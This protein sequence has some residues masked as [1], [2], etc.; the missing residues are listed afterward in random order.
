MSRLRVLI[1]ASLLSALAATVPVAVMVYATWDRAVSLEQDR[2]REIAE[3]ALRRA[4]QSYDES[5][6]ALKSAEA[7]SSP[8]CGEEHIRRMQTLVMTS[9]SVDQMGYF[10]GGK[11]RCTSWGSFDGDVDQPSADHV[12]SDGAGIKVDV[13]PQATN[14]R[15]V[16]AILYGSY[17]V[18]VDPRRFVDVIADPQVK[19]ALASPDGRLLSSQTGMDPELR[20]RLL[21]EPGEGLDQNT[22][23]ATA[24]NSE[25]LAIATAPRTALVAT[26][27]QQAWLFVPL[28]LLLAAACTTLVVWLSRRRLSLRGE[29][30]IAIRKRELYLHYQPIIELDT[31]ICVGAEA[32]VRWQRPDGSQIRPDIFVPL[33]EENGLIT[34]LTDLVIENVVS[35]MRELLVQDRSAHIAINLAAEDIISGRALKS[36]TQRMAGSGILPQQ[37]WLEATER[38]FLDADRAR[39]MLAAARR[40]GH[41]IAIDDFGVGYSSLQYLEQLPLDALKIDKSF[42]DA[43]G[44]ESAT[45]PVT[46]HIINMAKELGLFVVAEGVETEPQLAYLHSQKVQFG[47]GWLFSRPLPRDE[48]IAFH[49]Q[50]QQRYGAAREDMQNPRS[51]PIEQAGVEE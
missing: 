7:S 35:D 36:I 12:T 44:T 11:L 5:L 41:S 20:Q 17:D 45:T 14:R 51:V 33:A 30:S 3:R 43:I 10:E 21:R 31:G 46:P 49:R 29:L 50:R 1:I 34:A 26:F 19:L 39:T 2:L 15:S 24:R 4:D 16:L 22:L 40:A 37:I 38:G 9:P 28:G 42:I 25:W 6:A 32:L 27:R 8:P 48:F 18:L 47:Q 13:R 23:Y